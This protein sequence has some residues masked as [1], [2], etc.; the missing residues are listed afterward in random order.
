MVTGVPTVI[1]SDVFPPSKI[2]DLQVELNDNGFF[3]SWTAPG[4]DYDSGKGG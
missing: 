3:L 1:P 4:D 2:T